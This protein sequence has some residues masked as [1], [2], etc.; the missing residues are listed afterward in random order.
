MRKIGKMGNMEKGSLMRRQN[1][2]AVRW[3]LR[4]MLTLPLFS[5]WSG[6]VTDVQM[7]DFV[8][9]QA[10]LTATNILTSQVVGALNLLNQVL[11]GPQVTDVTIR[12]PAA[13]N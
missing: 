1:N 5:F 4:G 3:V 13:P 9:S 12:V 8:R 2:R 6:C 7:Q 11:T 10:A